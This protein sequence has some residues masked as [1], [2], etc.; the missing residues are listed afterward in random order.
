MALKVRAILN[1]GVLCPK[2]PDDFVKHF[3]TND[4]AV[5]QIES[6]DVETVKY[7]QWKRVQDGNKFRH[8][9]VEEE[10]SKIQFMNIMESDLIKFRQHVFRV[11]HQYNELRRIRENLPENELLVWMDFAENFQC[12][13]VEEVQSAYWNASLV[14]LHTMVVYFPEGNRKLVQS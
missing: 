5:S 13:S 9:E 8:K 7:K 14:S 11:K 3:S 1:I 12:S 2:N 10:V 4:A 6:A